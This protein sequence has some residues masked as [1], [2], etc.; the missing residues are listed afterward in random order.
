MTARRNESNASSG[1]F[2]R[3]TLLRGLGA[4]LA[5]PALESL[6]PARLLAAPEGA[7]LATTVGGA[8]LRTAFIYIPN[9]VIQDT[10]WPTGE[11]AEF[12]LGRTMEPLAGLKSQIQVL[13]GLDH[14]HATAGPDGPGDHARA[15]GTFLTGV[16]V[17]KTAGADIHAGV[18]IDQVIAKQVGHQTR[19]R[20]LELSCDTVRKSGNCDSGYSCAYQ[21]NLA[22]SAPTTPLS[23]EPNPR[24]VFE[25]LFGAGSPG[26]RQANFKLRQAQQRSILD[27][28]LDDARQLQKQLGQR[29]QKKLDEFLTNVREIET[30]IARTEQFGDTPNPDAETPAGIPSSYEEHIQLMFSMLQLAFE[31]DSTRVATL[32]LAHDGSNRAFPDIG[33]PEGHHHLSHHQN[34]KE[35]ISKISDI[36]RWYVRQLG[37]FLEKLDQAKDIDG[38]SVL[39]NSMIVYGGGNADGNRHTHSN[40]PVILAG[41]GGGTLTPGRFVKL[42]S[43][44]MS[45][46]F[47]S[48]ADRMGVTELPRFGDSTKRVEGI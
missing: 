45:N 17:K 13:G 3:R 5:L 10:W 44:P 15:N 28:V 42:G 35:W 30:R 7:A 6:V 33:I 38:T 31:T 34:N 14:V 8:P 48:L 11:G 12:E 46:L 32:L 26:E 18:S 47:L 20:S 21:F 41:G 39:H 16:R 1:R 29:D 9:G 2:N 23:P 24:L 19:F 22:W 40:L 27:F 4:C 37:R 25:R 36:D 43:Q